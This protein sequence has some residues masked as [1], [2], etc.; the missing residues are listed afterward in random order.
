MKLGS[1]GR[2][3]GGYGELGLVL[4]GAM[5]FKAGVSHRG[6]ESGKGLG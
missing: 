6:W 2:G 5:G 3:G 4:M 1:T